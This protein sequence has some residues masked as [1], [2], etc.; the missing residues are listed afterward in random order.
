[1]SGRVALCRWVPNVSAAAEHG[2]STATVSGAPASW[3]FRSDD[4]PVLVPLWR[5]GRAEPAARIGSGTVRVLTVGSDA[6]PVEAFDEAGFA[7]VRVPQ[8]RGVCGERVVAVLALGECVEVGEQ[9]DGG[10]VVG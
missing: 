9:C 4:R 1:M 6:G 3:F 5:S 2:W 10:V 7:G 8:R